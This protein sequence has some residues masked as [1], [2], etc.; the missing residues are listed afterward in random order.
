MLGMCA[1]GSVC[2]MCCAPHVSIRSLMRLHSVYMH[3]R[4]SNVGG[5]RDLDRLECFAGCVRNEDYRLPLRA[6]VAT[7]ALLSRLPLLTVL[8]RDGRIWICVGIVPTSTIRRRRPQQWLH[9]TD[10]GFSSLDADEGTVGSFFTNTSVAVEHWTFY[11]G[12]RRG[13]YNSSPP[14]PSARY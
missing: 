12:V 7:M 4:L 10:G 6:N 11:N 13:P 14:G 3:A 9:V 2:V 5:L 8:P 1:N